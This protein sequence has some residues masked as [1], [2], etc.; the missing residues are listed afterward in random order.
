MHPFNRAIIQN[1]DDLSPD[2]KKQTEAVCDLF[3][4][5]A[6]SLMV[7]DKVIVLNALNLLTEFFM[8]ELRDER[9]L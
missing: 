7:H 4:E 8:G 5:L 6:E 3:H 2:E 1:R 9:R